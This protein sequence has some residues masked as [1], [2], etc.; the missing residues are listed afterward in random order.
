M[1]VLYIVIMYHFVGASVPYR[2]V[3]AFAPYR[4]VEASMPYRFVGASVP[5]RTTGVA[6][7]CRWL[8]YSYFYRSFKPYRT[9]KIYIDSY[10]FHF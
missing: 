4:F 7:A 9:V 2:I 1:D 5:Y 6:G 3:G 8:S 10:S